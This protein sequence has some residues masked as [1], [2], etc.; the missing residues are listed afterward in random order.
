MDH[1]DP[2]LV[3]IILNQLA[4][5]LRTGFRFDVKG[6]LHKMLDIISWEPSVYLHHMTGFTR[7]ELWAKRS[8]IVWIST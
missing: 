8:D 5:T 2:Q 7:R 3:A 1:A 4:T 6:G